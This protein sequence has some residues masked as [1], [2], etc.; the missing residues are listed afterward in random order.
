MTEALLQTRGTPAAEAAPGSPGAAGVR[1]RRILYVTHRF[2]YPPNDGARVRAFHAI[3][4]LAARNDV[5]VAAPVRGE[6]GACVAEL[7]AL[8]VRV[9]SA[10]IGRAVGLARTCLSAG[11]G[12]SASR[13]YFDQ[14]GLRRRLRQ[15][16]AAER[17]DLAIV[18]CSAVAPYVCDLPIPVKVLDYVDV[19]SAKWL[20]YRPFANLPSKLLYSLEGHFLGRLERAMARR[21]DLCLTT[22]AFEDTSLQM[23]AATEPGRPV[24][25]TV[26]RNGVDLDFFHPTDASY[27]PDRICFLGRMDYFPNEQAMVRFCADVL[28]R[29]QAGRP[30]LKLTIVGADPGPFVQA[31]ARLPGVEVTGRVQDVRPYVW[32]SAAT[33][34]P[35]LIARGTQNKI[36]ESMAL[37][38]PVVASTLAA[39]G[40]QA[41]PGKH[42][43]S[44]SGAAET[45][46]AVERLL[47]AP[48]ERARLAQAARALVE[49][50]Y[51]WTTTM[52]DLESQLASLLEDPSGTAG[53]SAGPSGRDL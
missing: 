39:R 32:R 51:S 27:D 19:D 47:Q 31:L 17:F 45:A 3:Q 12:R 18:H 44:A 10:P 29:L 48:G 40:V 6:E 49:R 24:T 50:D 41:Q 26:V 5:T 23:L 53:R 37:G 14:P 25:S 36:L 46:E 34:A 21:F 15:L 38:V 33:V 42:L 35:L 28:P 2:P 30:N 8:G 20:D 1:D 16:A 22:T 43:L 52:Q 9:V 7:E 11:L 4:H 13:G